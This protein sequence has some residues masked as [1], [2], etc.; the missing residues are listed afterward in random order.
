[1]AG[2]ALRAALYGT[3]I[4]GASHRVISQANISDSYLLSVEEQIERAKKEHAILRTQLAEI[5]NGKNKKA[6]EA[7]L[8]DIRKKEERLSALKKERG[9]LPG[10]F[11]M[12]AAGLVLDKEAFA[13]I[14]DAARVLANQA[15]AERM[16]GK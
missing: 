15:N 6:I 7:L 11:F 13:K 2:K 12:K 9:F 3:P 5:R 1:M 14:Y 8:S 4:N 10:N 16:M